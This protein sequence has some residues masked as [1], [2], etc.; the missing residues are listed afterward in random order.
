MNT[1]VRDSH[2]TRDH[3]PS[4]AKPSPCSA[5]IVLRVFE[6]PRIQLVWDPIAAGGDAVPFDNGQ[7]AVE[8]IVGFC[9]LRLAD[10]SFNL[11][12]VLALRHERHPGNTDPTTADPIFPK[13]ISVITFA[14]ETVCSVSKLPK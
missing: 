1:Y 13:I 3:I 14:A 4:L 12:R 10:L 5:S 2:S 7:D 8:H 9:S 11:S 6:R